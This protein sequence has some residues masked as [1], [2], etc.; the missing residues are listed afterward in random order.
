MG[1]FDNKYYVYAQNKW[2]YHIILFIGFVIAVKILPW[3]TTQ[4][5]KFTENVWLQQGGSWAIAYVAAIYIIPELG[6]MLYK[7]TIGEN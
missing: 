2:M 6:F 4:V 1:M 5:S 3:I 7:T